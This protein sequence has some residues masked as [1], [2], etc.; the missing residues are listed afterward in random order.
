MKIIRAPPTEETLGLINPEIAIL[1]TLRHPRIS[2]LMCVCRELSFTE[3]TVALVSEYMARGSLYNLLHPSAPR[4]AAVAA[5]LT[6]I[7]KLIIAL[8]IADGLRFLHHARI[9]HRDLKS[10]NVLVSADGRARIADFGLSKT[11]SSLQSHVSGLV[12][13][14]AWMSPEAY[15]TEQ[16]KDSSDVY[17]FGV[18]LWEILTQEIPW[19]GLTQ[20]Q[21]MAKLVRRERLTFV[22]RAE[23]GSSLSIME[24]KFN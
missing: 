10:P 9:L 12:G 1:A 19:A 7:E 14:A 22:R 8:D 21:I 17:S 3:G 13:T 11:M 18:V 20:F 4:A 6:T 2:G 15:E 5:G 16:L 24:G 23:A